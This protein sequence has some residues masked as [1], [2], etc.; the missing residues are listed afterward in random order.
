MGVDANVDSTYTMK[1]VREQR[2]PAGT[3]AEAG[4]QLRQ[5]LPVGVGVHEA[6]VDGV[7]VTASRKSLSKYIAVATKPVVESPEMLA[8]PPGSVCWAF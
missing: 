8:A 2:T 6:D 4:Q 5:A 3:A 7:L 1:G